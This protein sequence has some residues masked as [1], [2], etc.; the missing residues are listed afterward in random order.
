MAEFHSVANFDGGPARSDD[1]RLA[2]LALALTPRMGPTRCH[3][4][5][6]KLGAA[7]RLFTASLTELE[8]TGMPAEAAQFVFDGRAR[9]AALKEVEGISAQ[10]A[11]FL[12][13]ED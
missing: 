6:Q 11:T 4:A 5:L 9:D 7:D 10:A 1:A 3:R 8:S 12:T 2:W 13:P